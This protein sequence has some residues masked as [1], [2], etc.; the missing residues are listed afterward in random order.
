MPFSTY[1]FYWLLLMNH[2]KLDFSLVEL[3]IIRL[4]IETE[5]EAHNQTVGGAWRILSKRERWN[6][7]SQRGEGHLHKNNP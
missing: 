5:A 3:K 1:L 4:M 6:S 7:R 2:T